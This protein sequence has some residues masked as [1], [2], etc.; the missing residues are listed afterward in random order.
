M[1]SEAERV[2]EWSSR[3]HLY[4]LP[5][6]EWTMHKS[7]QA[8]TPCEWI[9]ICRCRPAYQLARSLRECL[10]KHGVQS[11]CIVLGTQLLVAEAKVVP[12]NVRN[13][14][15]LGHDQ[16]PLLLSPTAERNHRLCIV[17]VGRTLKGTCHACPC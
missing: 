9:A 17:A 4:G 2:H 8:H 14:R 13:K 11:L 3:H 7:G 16:D 12:T 5:T 1:A 6:M 10:Q 15:G